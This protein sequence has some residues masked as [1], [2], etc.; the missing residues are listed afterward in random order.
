MLHPRLF[1]QG[2]DW[3]WASSGLKEM[4][5]ASGSQ[6]CWAPSTGIFEE[7]RTLR[8]FLTLHMHTLLI[9]AFGTVL[10]VSTFALVLTL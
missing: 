6:C 7:Q 9:G 3:G 4:R 8:F 2:P 1:S 10:D 5:G